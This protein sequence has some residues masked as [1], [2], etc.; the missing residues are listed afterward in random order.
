MKPQSVIEKRVEQLEYLEGHVL[1]M[2]HKPE[3]PEHSV[4]LEDIRVRLQVLRWVLD[5]EPQ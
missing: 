2:M 3:L 5:Q 1:E 4:L